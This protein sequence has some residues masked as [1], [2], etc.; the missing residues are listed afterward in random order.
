MFNEWAHCKQ[1]YKQKGLK[2]L[3]SENKIIVQINL[4]IKL[5]KKI[6]AK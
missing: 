1:E 3:E 2:I 4:R 5:R 6:I